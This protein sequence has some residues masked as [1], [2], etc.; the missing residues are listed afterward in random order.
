MLE[1]NAQDH[2]YKLDGSPISGVTTILKEAGLSDFG[3]VNAEVLER[4]RKFGNAVHLACHLYNINDLDESTLDPALRP[5]L[6]AW[7]KFL[8]DFHITVIDSEKPIASKRFRIGG[9]PDI[10]GVNEVK[11]LVEIKTGDILPVA[12]IQTAAYEEIYGEDKPRQEKIKRRMVV[13]LCQDGMYKLAPEKF[14]SKSD[15]SVFLAALTIANTKKKWG[16]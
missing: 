12:A 9:M 1:F 15:F 4:S 6:D 5:C 8:K 14:F 16:M 11:N 3:M 7:V 2:T 10:I 13:Q